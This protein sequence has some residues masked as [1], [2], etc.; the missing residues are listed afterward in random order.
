M[1][2]L[3]DLFVPYAVRTDAV[4]FARELTSQRLVGVAYVIPTRTFLRLHG[5]VAEVESSLLILKS[6]DTLLHGK[7]SSVLKNRG[8]D[9]LDISAIPIVD[10][11][12]DYKDWIL[13]E[14]REDDDHR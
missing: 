12:K 2:R 8:Q 4:S 10:S 14:I 9:T 13:D 7:L 6:T 1:R 11:A 5:Q 3:I